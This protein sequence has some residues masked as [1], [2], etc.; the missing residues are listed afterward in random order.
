MRVTYCFNIFHPIRVLI[1]KL[2]QSIIINQ[3]GHDYFV[4][5]FVLFFRVGPFFVSF[6][7]KGLGGV[8]KRITIL[9]AAKYRKLSPAL[10]RS[11][12]E[13]TRQIEEYSR[14]LK[15]LVT[16]GIFT[17]RRV[18]KGCRRTLDVLSDSIILILA[19]LY[20]PSPQFG[21]L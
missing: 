1:S 9:I 13:E 17:L 19:R 16:N 2:L 11:R 6:I 10:I 15:W 12:P 20:L 4:F 5:S 8:A 21:Q 14:L 18:C 3:S 7:L